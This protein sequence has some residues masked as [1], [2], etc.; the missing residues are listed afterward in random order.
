M[1]F[2]WRGVRT[3]CALSVLQFQLQSSSSKPATNTHPATILLLLP[4]IHTPPPPPAFK[5]LNMPFLEAADAA[6]AALLLG[7]LGG[8]W[9]RAA[10]AASVAVGFRSRI[11]GCIFLCVFRVLD[12]GLSNLVKTLKR[13]KK[14]TAANHQNY[15]PALVAAQKWWCSSSSITSKMHSHE[16]PNLV[17]F[18]NCCSSNSRR[19]KMMIWSL[20]TLTHFCKWVVRRRRKMIS[21]SCKSRHS[22]FS[23][24]FF[25]I[26]HSFLPSCANPII[27]LRLKKVM[28]LLLFLGFRI[29]SSMG[30]RES[31]TDTSPKIW[32]AAVTF[33]K[34][35]LVTRHKI[36]SGRRVYLNNNNYEW[37][38]FFFS[39]FQ[40][41]ALPV[42]S[43]WQSPE[44]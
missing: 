15:S 32:R 24:V 19:K 33:L 38:F 21:L 8:I 25:F 14:K 5:L 34:E 6:A 42:L 3:P 37:F 30:E 2:A 26:S 28:L 4:D 16:N 40:F 29:L 11:L 10:A 27:Y 7:G 1:G 13:K 36:N 20:Q 23:L 22:H 17:N 44:P 41:Q 35:L 9:D 12:G 18:H 39:E 31:G 43:E